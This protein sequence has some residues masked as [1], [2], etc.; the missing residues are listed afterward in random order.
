MKLSFIYVLV[1]LIFSAS[2]AMN[3]ANSLYLDPF[4]P[5]E[6]NSLYYMDGEKQAVYIDEELEVSLDFA[7][8][9]KVE[10]E[11][12]IIFKVHF[13]NT[14]DESRFL[15]APSNFYFNAQTLHDPEEG[16]RHKVEHKAVFA[17]EE[18]ERLNE[19]IDEVESG[20]LVDLI[21]SIA[22]SGDD[23]EREEEI[24]EEVAELQQQKE[25][26]DSLLKRNTLHPDSSISGKIAFKAARGVKELE[27]SLPV[28]EHDIVFYFEQKE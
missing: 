21:S 16:K 14:S 8:Y 28:E 6:S 24:K 12:L 19:E 15:I 23:E 1:F 25:F 17:E 20:T 10:G 18:I 11:N 4:Y 5:S 26:Y 9:E 27:I 3:P 2:C 7:G 13:R 22:G